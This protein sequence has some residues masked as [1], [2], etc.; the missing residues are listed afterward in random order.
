MLSEIEALRGM[1]T[2]EALPIVE[3]RDAATHFVRLSVAAVGEAKDDDEEVLKLLKPWRR[4]TEVHA[5]LADEF[6]KVSK[7]RS[8]DGYT[9]PDAKDAVERS[10]KCRLLNQLI[11]DRDFPL[12]KAAAKDALERL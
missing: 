8:I 7:G 11:D 10:W 1:T 3:R 4:D 2:D 12:I 9:L 6:A 5:W